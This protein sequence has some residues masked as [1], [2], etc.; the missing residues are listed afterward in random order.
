ME[1]Y[2]RQGITDG[3]VG[4]VFHLRA[5]CAEAPDSLVHKLSAEEVDHY[6]KIL[7]IRKICLKC[8]KAVG[9]K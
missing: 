7:G 4:T 9:R 2:L 6:R 5:K 1:V 8:R 3:A